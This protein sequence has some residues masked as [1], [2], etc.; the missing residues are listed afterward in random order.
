MFFSN[1]FSIPLKFTQLDQ[2]YK[3]VPT[4]SERRAC[5]IYK[6]KPSNIQPT[7]SSVVSNLQSSVV[8]EVGGRGGSL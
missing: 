1:P 8:E 3:N 7:F 4:S 5:S 6:N 2:A